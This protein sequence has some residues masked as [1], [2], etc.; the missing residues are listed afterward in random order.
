MEAS[1]LLYELY[2]T[3]ER[4]NESQYRNALYKFCTTRM[5]FI[6]KLV[7]EISFT[8]RPKIEEHMLVVMDKSAHEEHLSQPLQTK[9]KQ[10]KIAV[11]SLTGDNGIFNVTNKNKNLFLQNQ[12]LINMVLFRFLSHRVLMKSIA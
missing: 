10:F 3:V 12:L 11:T 8:K 7:E 5:E 9:T 2:K 6:S 1:S 4:Q